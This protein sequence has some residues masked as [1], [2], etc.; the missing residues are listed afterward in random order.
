MSAATATIQ[1]PPLPPRPRWQVQH[2]RFLSPTSEV[3]E[4]ASR[5]VRKPLQTVLL[6]TR[7]HQEFQR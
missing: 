7:M 6:R 4:F 2:I 5:H 3:S 1:R